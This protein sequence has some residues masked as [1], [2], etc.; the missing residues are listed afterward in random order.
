MDMEPVDSS[1][2]HSVGYDP[3]SRRM[4][5]QFVNGNVHDYQDVPAETHQAL[6]ASDS[7]GGHLAKHVKPAHCS[8]RIK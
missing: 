6:M 8:V 7:K 3:E 2:V 5:V 4:R 1:N